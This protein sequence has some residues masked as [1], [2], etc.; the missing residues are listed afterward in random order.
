MLLLIVWLR[1]DEAIPYNA[2]RSRLS[3]TFL[4]RIRQ[5]RVRAA[6]PSTE[7]TGFSLLIPPGLC[8][9][10]RTRQVVSTR[11]YPKPSTVV[12]PHLFLPARCISVTVNVRCSYHDAPVTGRK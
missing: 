3:I 4:P 11:T 5:I 10:L 8:M 6:I 7:I 12:A 1:V 2:A 9:V